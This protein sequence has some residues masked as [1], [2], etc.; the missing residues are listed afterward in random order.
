[1]LKEMEPRRTTETLNASPIPININEGRAT[2]AI[3][4]PERSQN[5][6]KKIS[7][8][9]GLSALIVHDLRNPLGT[10]FAGA[11]MLMLSDP[12]ETQVKRLA[13]NIYLAAGR[14]RELLA[15]LADEIRGNRSTSGI[16]KILDVITAGW[17]P[18]LSAAE[19]QDVRLATDVPGDLEVPLE[20][21]RMERVF[22]NLI[23]N[24]LEA[25]PF[26]GTIRIGAWKADNSLLIAVEDTGPGIPRGIR[27]RLFET[28]VT[29][30][31]DHGLG[32]GLAL[33]R[34]AVLDHGG[35]MWIEPAA[36]ARFVI[37]LPL[38]R[39]SEAASN[40]ACLADG[41]EGKAGDCGFGPV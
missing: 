13:A 41:E 26:G 20:R 21:R 3:R 32:L 12:A 11:E 15:D 27:D 14:M 9:G 39:V 7:S 31:K 5:R 2:A 36:G 35:D 38:T 22:F 8:I 29:A 10:V 23:T 1:M 6:R 24:A 18:A 25:M 37:R 17:E 16:C 4:L 34:Q 33:S 30:G 28:F 40:L 19:R